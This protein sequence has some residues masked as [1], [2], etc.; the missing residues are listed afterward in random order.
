MEL[1]RF[2]GFLH[3]ALV[4]FPLVLL[5]VSVGLELIGF[6]RRDAR[7]TWG[8]QATLLLGTAATLFAF[9]AGNFAEIWAARDGVPQDPMEFHELL[10]TI[11]SWAFVFLTAGRLFLGVGANRRWM[12]GYLVAATF[13][14]G[15]LIWT[16]H[17]GAMLVYEHGAG[18]HAAG[19]APRPTHEDLATLLQKQTF[20]ALF[21]SN[22]MHHIF[23]WLV[24]VLSIMLLVDLVSPVY[25]EKLRRL[26]PLLLLAGGVFLMIFS[27]QDAWPLYQVRPFR[28]WSDKEVLMHKTYAIL[29][30]LMGLRGLLKRKGEPKPTRNIQSRAMA[31]FAL[32]GGALLFTHVHSN[33]P[34]AN[35]AAGVYVHHTVM[36]LIALSIGAVKLMEDLLQQ[37]R[38]AFGKT[39]APPNLARTARGLGWAY[40]GLML[41]ESIFLVNYNEGLPWFLGYRNLS[42]TAPHH[43]LVAP[44]GGD[45]AELCYDPA[46]QRFDLYLYSQNN[47]KPLP[48]SARSVQAV[49]KVGSD[50]TACVLD[51]APG[52]ASH[53]VGRADF[54][55]GAAMFEA[56]ALVWPGDR[57]ASVAPLKADFEPW[58]DT[59]AARPHT[60]LAW[61]CPMH[62]AQGAAQPGLCPLC[63]M[64]LVPNK[65]PRPWPQLHDANYQME[66]AISAPALQRQTARPIQMA[67]SRPI[68]LAQR[69]LAPAAERAI[70]GA[71]AT[72]AAVAHP[73]P[74]QT[75]RLTLRPRR[76]DGTIVRDLEVVHTKKLHL[77]VASDDLAYFDHVHP[78]QQSD[79]SLTL[80]YAFPHPGRFSLYAD[81]TPT[82]DRN[83]VFQLPVEVSGSPAP[84]QPLIVTPAQAKEFGEYR[85]E[86]QMTPDPPVRKDETTLTFTISRKGLPVTDL[87]PFL[88]AGG[89][90]VILSEDGR[91]YLH[92]HPLEMGG[93]RF[94]PS[95]TFHTLF[96]RPGAYKVW[97][98]FQH[99]GKPLTFDFV[100]KVD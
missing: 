33:A 16:G 86:L 60:R 75:V 99:Q 44:L 7:F 31:I 32:V 52:D 40:A 3:P 62:E 65:P 61:V 36:G 23:G 90:C 39:A 37:R 25:G 30:L 21:Y 100:I 26:A 56:T 54:L 43:G 4:H 9:V 29:L 17:R 34:Y 19:I 80:D 11:T 68:R 98:Q 76:S 97:A 8:A 95:I 15:L 85:V 53:F 93:D 48:I 24:L 58:V 12:A 45:R 79:G 70:G 49:V 66:L 14:C 13:C 88:G 67:S 87:E 94:G 46:A 22:M 51:P 18:V 71:A 1:A 64:H 59:L 74:G 10:A 83:Q 82:G 41:I 78:M 84:A 38:Q 5:L 81:I 2:F 63:G 50:T 20:D 42:L 28:P 72:Y 96:P 89:H 47:N 91:S 69:D 73:A 6:L 55:R 57:A 35:V 92:S 77:I 27:D